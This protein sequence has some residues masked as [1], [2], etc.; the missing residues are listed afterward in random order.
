[1]K[2][3]SHIPIVAQ[4]FHKIDY[5]SRLVSIGSCFSEHIGHK[6]SYFKFQNT[7]NPFGILF[8]PV[9]IE[10]LVIN[11]INQEPYDGSQLIYHFERYHCFDAHSS[12]SGGDEDEV[13]SGLNMAISSTFDELSSASHI[14]I[15]L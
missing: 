14:I 4:R 10:T 7:V 1:M 9:A 15:T 13:L 5:D 2:L 8:T 6:L 12:M 11:A 3:Q